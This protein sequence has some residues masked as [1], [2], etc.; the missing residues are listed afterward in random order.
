MIKPKRFGA[1]L[2]LLAFT[3][4]AATGVAVVPAKGTEILWG[5][6]GIPHI[7]ARDHRSLFYAYGYAQ[8]E[9]HA[10]LLL[11][12]YVQ[13]RGR[14]AEFYG[15]SYLDS[16]RWVRVNGIPERAKVWATQ[17]SPE[18]G[19]LL[20]AFVS[21]L[22]AWGAEH[23]D[24]LSAPAK[25]ALPVTVEDVLAHCQ[26][27][28]HFDWLISQSRMETRL[29]G[30]R[31]APHGSNEWAIAPSRSA[32]GHAMLLSNSHLQW[33]DRHTSFEVQLQAPGVTSYA[34]VGVGFPPCR[35]C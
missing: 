31:D 7:C 17:Q 1:L 12:L 6:Y 32:S 14:A 9:A 29:K 30:A 35:H 8:M 22:N 11:R 13:A 25:A 10:E 5:R 4:T 27:V 16:D 15:E 21:G 34:A 24:S 3:L 20:T 2:A 33:G 28:I 26:R 23:A 19:P 18:F